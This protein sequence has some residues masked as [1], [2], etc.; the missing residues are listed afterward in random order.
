MILNLL[1][2]VNRP[3][4]IVCSFVLDPVPAR[5]AVAWFDLLPY[6]ANTK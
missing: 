5:I 1:E 4:K 2:D 6:S 3:I